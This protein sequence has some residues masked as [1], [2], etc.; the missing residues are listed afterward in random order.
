MRTFPSIGL[1]LLAMGLAAAAQTT[2]DQNAP[3]NPSAT[4]QAPAPPAP[5]YG[6][7]DVTA[8]PPITAL[9]AP[10]LEPNLQPRS[11]LVGGV[12][13][14]ESIDTN[15]NEAFN[16]SHVQSVTRLLGGLTMQRLWS[17]YNFG[18]AYIGGLGIYSTS[19]PT[20]RNI[21]EFQVQQ[22][23]A[24][25]TGQF[26]LRDSFSYLPEGAFGFATY[27]GATGFELGL[28]ALGEGNGLVGVGL[29]G[30][31]GIL[32]SSQFGSLGQTPRITNV[33][34]AD[35]VQALSPRSSITAAG[36]YALVH[37]TDN[38]VEN[39]INSHQAGGQFGYNYAL[40][41][42]DQ[43]GVAYGYRE[44]VFPSE[45]GADNISSHIVQVLYG[46]RITG[47]LDFVVG[48]GPQWTTIDNP[49]QHTTNLSGSGR[50]T[51][52]YR[53]PRT[54]LALSYMAYDTAGSGFFAGAESQIARVGV[55]RQI[56][57][58]WDAR[59]DVGFSHNRRLQD[60]AAGIDAT[61]FNYWFAGAG[62]RRAFTRNFGAFVSYQFNRQ[63]FEGFDCTGPNCNT[64]QRHVVTFGADWHFRPIRLD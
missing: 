36:S 1:L 23:I 46:H 60:A 38:N 32:G 49:L 2:P 18:A 41:P 62:V 12:Q 14:S 58:R 35:V 10:S 29:G 30:Q 24:W 34:V 61:S 31:Y 48:A 52:R 15:V 6:T 5:A 4:Q 25:K 63:V 64:T 22:G 56:A 57:R 37:F 53:W 27:G 43:L 13:G 44:F 59:A 28:G 47:R 42:K 19:D 45:V 7:A 54:T 51:L 21:Q 11:M 39:L 40:T 3:A 26:Y 55:G 17:R 33:T 20:V 16:T 8:N 9:D 50:F